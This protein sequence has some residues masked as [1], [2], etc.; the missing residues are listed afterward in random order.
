[1]RPYKHL[2][3]NPK[4]REIAR[5]SGPFK[6]WFVIDGKRT[7]YFLGGFSGRQ[8]FYDKSRDEFLQ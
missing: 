5:L 8:I 6:N 2:L 3:V 1:M 4:G 7:G